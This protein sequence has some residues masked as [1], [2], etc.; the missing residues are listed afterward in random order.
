LT[1]NLSHLSA[2]DSVPSLKRSVIIGGIG[3]CLASMC[4][5]A[6]VAFAERW[7]YRQL[8]FI[9]AYLVWTALFIILGGGVL[10]LL[11]RKSFG[12]IKFYLIFALAFF[13]YAVGWTGAYFSMRGSKVGEWVA[14]FVGSILMGL[15]FSVGFKAIRLTLGFSA[16]LFVSNSLGYFVGSML[17]DLVGGKIGM[18]LW[19]TIYGLCLG[20]GLGAVIYLAQTQMTNGKDS[21]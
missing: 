17:N 10:S 12:L 8:G 21:K 6:T 9:N 11:V 2:N 15:V 4:V 18:M 14:S 5:F 13:G 16:L 3:F 7:M 19:G 20:A 1:V